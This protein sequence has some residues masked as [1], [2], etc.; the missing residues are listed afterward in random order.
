MK[1]INRRTFLL[2]AGAGGA[3]AAAGIAVPAVTLL[4][5]NKDNILTFRAV[6]GLPTDARLPNYCSYVLEG[7]VDLT[8]GSG[9]ITRSMHAGDPG[10]MSSIVWPGFTQNI[11]VT[12]AQQSGDTI[13]ITGVVD[14]RSQLLYGESANVTIQINNANRTVEA[15]F[16]GSSVALK[17]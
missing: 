15:P 8:N 5:K 6:G 2:V 13:K 17:K 14:D 11:R 4:A 7:H 3:A 1:K 9:L 12:G 10:Q 16:V